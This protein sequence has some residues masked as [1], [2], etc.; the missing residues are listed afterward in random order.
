M[1]HEFARIC[2]LT[3]ASG[4][5]Y[6][7]WSGIGGGPTIIVFPIVAYEYYRRSSCD[8]PG[9]HRPARRKAKDTYGDTHGVC[10]R[11]LHGYEAATEEVEAELAEVDERPRG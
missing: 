1:W 10:V 5:W 2:G 9:C 4:S 3:D 7:F 8:V 11:H 6:L